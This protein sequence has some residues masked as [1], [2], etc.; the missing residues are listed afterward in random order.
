M[1]RSICIQP[2]VEQDIH[3]IYSY[4]AEI[5]QDRAMVFFDAMRLKSLFHLKPVIS[6]IESL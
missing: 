1:N 4:L 5:D 3:D 2:Q 6:W